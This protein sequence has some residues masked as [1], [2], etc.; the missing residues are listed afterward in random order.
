MA[1][2]VLSILFLENGVPQFEFAVPWLCGRGLGDNLYAV[3]VVSPFNLR[4]LHSEIFAISFVERPWGYENPPT[5]L[6]TAQVDLG[7]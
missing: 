3:N 5:E 7:R 1:Q 4:V 6:A 2:I